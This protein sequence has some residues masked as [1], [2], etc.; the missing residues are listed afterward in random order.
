MA[1]NRKKQSGRKNPSSSNS[2]GS[3]SKKLIKATVFSSAVFF[4]LIFIFSL[5]ASRREI[6]DSVM[7]VLPFAAGAA[8]GFAGGRMIAKSFSDKT[9]IYCLICAAVQSVAVSIVLLL[10][11]GNIGLKT[12]IFFVLIFVFYSLGAFWKRSRKPKRKI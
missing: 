3:V 11:V 10:T 1:E 7:S 5:A 4:V 2:N 9:L 12:L 6:P 8:S